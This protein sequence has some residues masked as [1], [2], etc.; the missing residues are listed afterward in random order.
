MQQMFEFDVVGGTAARKIISE[1]RSEIVSV[2]RDAYLAH[3]R[4][5]SI[6]PNSYFLRFPG[7]PSAR[8][9]ALP[10]YL[11]G[12]TDVAGIKWIGSFPEN[13]QNNIPRAS[14]VLLLNDYTTGYPF[15]CLEASQISAARTAASAV[16][17]AA[18]L[19]GRTEAEKIA[20][21]GSGIIARNIVEFFA[22]ESWSVGEFALH[23]QVPDY[24]RSLATH[25]RES[26]GHTASVSDSLSDA[27]KGADV[28]VLA[29]TS[30]LEGVRQA[31]GHGCGVAE[32]FPDVCGERPGVVGDLVVQGELAD[33][34]AL[35]GEELDD[36]AG[37]DAGADHGDLLG[38][39]AAEQPCRPQDGGGGRA[40]RADL[41]GLQAGEG[42][43]GGVVV[44][45]Q[46][47]R[48]PGDV[49]LDVFG[50]A[51]DPLDARDVRVAAQVGGQGDDPCA[52]FA[53]EAQEVAVGVDR[54]APVV[55]EVRVAD[56][57]DDFGAG[58]ADDLAGGG[59]AYHVE[60]KHLLHRS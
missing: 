11:G 44:E 54:I 60:L 20:V 49:V 19:L 52:R 41:R 29:T 3:H 16:L 56:H 32:A 43:A 21:V 46:D 58:L 48:R 33:R 8:I 15:A 22:A 28:V 59:A 40:C 55:G 4:G 27:L 39:G 13:I 42:V 45:Q 14:A 35:G 25:I 31:V 10:A 51:A 53:G 18:R 6:N 37:D 12:D 2:V 30:A 5:D 50:E 34:P 38:L 23:D 7:K 47:G 17:G 26:L 57:R 9:I 24:A 1:S 36:V